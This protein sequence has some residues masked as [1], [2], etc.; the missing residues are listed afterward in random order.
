MR[1]TATRID[2]FEIGLAAKHEADTL[3]NSE[4]NK[5]WRTCG[6]SLDKIGERVKEND[7]QEQAR[8]SRTS[9]DSR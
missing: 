7:G 6:D 4:T 8:S 2:E 1:S 3:I 9:T 5:N